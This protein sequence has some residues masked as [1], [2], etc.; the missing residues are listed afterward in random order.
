MPFLEKFLNQPRLSL[1]TASK[2]F[3]WLYCWLWISQVIKPRACRGGGRG[4]QETRK[5][6]DLQEEVSV[7]SAKGS[8]ATWRKAKQLAYP[9]GLAATQGETQ[10]LVLQ[11]P[12]LSREHGERPWFILIWPLF[13]PP[14]LPAF[15]IGSQEARD[16]GKYC[17]LS[18]TTEKSRTE[19]ACRENRQTTHTSAFMLS[20][21]VSFFLLCICTA[22]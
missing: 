10:Q 14:C 21:T 22:H 16:P 18:Y 13:S 1:E 9:A 7:S 11:T 12:I 6:R 4:S 3:Q 17:S 15:L 2:A 20:D 5:A 19:N 8:W